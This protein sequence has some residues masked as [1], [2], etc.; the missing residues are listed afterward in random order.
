MRPNPLPHVALALGLLAQHPLAQEQLA[1]AVVAP[2]HVATNRVGQPASDGSPAERIVRLLRAQR[3]AGHGVDPQLL[4]ALQ[5]LASD[6]PEVIVEVLLDGWL[7]AMDAGEEPMLANVYQRELALESLVGVDPDR[8]RRLIPSA[9]EL[10]STDERVLAAG[11]RLI[12]WTQ[13]PAEAR[14]GIALSRPDEGP[15]D[16]DAEGAAPLR[17]VFLR[18]ELRACLT[19]MLERDPST[20]QSLWPDLV[21]GTE[22]DRAAILGALGAAAHPRALPVLVDALELTGIDRRAV[23]EAIA[24][25]GRSFDP[26]LDR[27]A[28]DSLLDLVHS[29]DPALA[30]PAARALA[31]LD[32]P[33]AVP[34]LVARL[35]FADGAATALRDALEDLTG[36]RLPSD[37]AP[38]DAYLQAELEWSRVVMDGVTAR[39]ARADATDLVALLRPLAGRRL[40]RDELSRV[41][42]ERLEDG[43]R[44]VRTAC[45]SLLAQLG[46]PWA[47]DPLVGA[48]ESEPGELAYSQALSRIT[49]ATLGPD[50]AAWRA[51]LDARRP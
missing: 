27:R 34:A 20:A 45:A 33:L 4:E 42:C 3:N 13:A 47:V 25:A 21:A 46:S 48:L 14:R 32:D 19:H 37:P 7:P 38:W 31:A 10:R 29:P 15:T 2:P 9:A 26:E 5:G 41:L 8:V 28:V 51:W 17:S 40:Q 16:A 43:Y 22:G 23:L 18:A 24:S 11:M 39:L 1:P 50:A 36:A 12:A 44:P 49:G 30:S 35:R 6:A